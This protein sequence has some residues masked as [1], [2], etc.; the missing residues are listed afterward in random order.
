MV[1]Q[2][3]AQLNALPLPVVLM[4]FTATAEGPAAV[5]LAWATASEQNSAAFEVERSADGTV[6]KYLTTVAAAGSSSAPHRYAL[7]DGHLPAGAP[8]LYYRLRQVD[9]DGTTVYSPVRTVALNGPP[10]G[11]TL[12]LAPNPARLTALAGARPHT[13]VAVFDAVGR[14]ALTAT[15]DARGTAVLALP[16]HL[17]GGVYV[18]RSVDRAA[19]LVVE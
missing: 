7:R 8:T 18:V 1:A 13:P 15:A 12:T 19:R 9:A 4:A 5:R 11:L 10:G 6:F 17:P 3:L 16:A 14:L 2:Q